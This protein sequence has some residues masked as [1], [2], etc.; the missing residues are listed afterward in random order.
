MLEKSKKHCT[1][2]TEEGTIQST[3][4]CISFSIHTNAIARDNIIQKFYHRLMEKGICPTWHKVLALVIF[5]EQDIH[6]ACVLL[7]SWSI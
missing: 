2:R 7:H 4:V 5:Q 3:I 1:S 6:D